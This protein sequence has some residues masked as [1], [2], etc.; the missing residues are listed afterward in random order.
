MSTWPSTSK[1]MG[2]S[3]PP[4]PATVSRN[5][6]C[7][8]KSVPSLFSFATDLI[9]LTNSLLRSFGWGI[10]LKRSKPGMPCGGMA[11]LMSCRLGNAFGASEEVS[12]LLFAAGRSVSSGKPPLLVPGK[13]PVPISFVSVLTRL[14][15]YTSLR[16]SKQLLLTQIWPL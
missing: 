12:Y 8:K 4:H 14:C 9:R 11:F 13:L 3:F 15:G 1:L 6:R 2:L 7:L 5:D 10:V 16:P